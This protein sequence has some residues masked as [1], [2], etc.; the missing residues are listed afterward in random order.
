MLALTA[1]RIAD[2]IDHQ[3]FPSRI[4]THSRYGEAGAFLFCGNVRSH[5]SLSQR[6]GDGFGL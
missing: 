1:Q 3:A 5:D 2:L 4:P 6:F